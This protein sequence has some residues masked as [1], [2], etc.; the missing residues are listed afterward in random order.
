M[1]NTP[2]AA[3]DSA[4]GKATQTRL[5]QDQ[6]EAI[7]RRLAGELLPSPDRAPRGDGFAATGASVRPSASSGRGETPIV[8]APASAT[9]LLAPDTLR[10]LLE[11]IPDALVIADQEG[12]IVLV[13]SESERLFAYH[14]EELLGQPIEV[15]VPE[16]YRDR[17]VTDRAAYFAA[18]RVR[19]M[20]KGLELYGRRKDGREFP[21]EISLSPLA[22]DGKVLVVATIRDVSERRQAEAQLRKMEARYR[23]LVEGIPAVTFM[24]ALDEGVNELYVSPQIEELLGFS[25][26]EWLENPVLWYTQLHPDDRGRWHAEFARTCATGEPFRSV[27][28]FVSR[29]GRQVWVHGEAHVVRDEDGQP[30]FLQG[31]AFDIT[32]I[33]QAEEDLKALNATLEQ[34]VA[35]RTA[36]AE[37]RAAELARSNEALARF[38]STAAHDLSAPLV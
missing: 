6:A 12:R 36:E 16:R 7:L 38:A 11:A 15:L 25:Q 2:A 13:N 27:Y 23:T 19:P 26:A 34:R 33:K 22:A 28:R 35:E 17:H 30:L 5:T 10:G 21:V 18:P 32:G 3:L 24:A 37:Q 31:V 14:R 20:G 9:G 1:A 8:H 4:S 29:S